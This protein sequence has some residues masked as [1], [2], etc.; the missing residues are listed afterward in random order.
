VPEIRHHLTYANVAAT[1]AL[2]L[3]LGGGVV[4]AASK[5]RGLDIRADAIKSKH[6]KDDSLTGADV[7]ESSLDAGAL[8]QGPPGSPDTAEQVRDK[9]LTVDGPGSGIDA[10]ALDGLDSTKIGEVT[11]ARVN[12]TVQTPGIAEDLDFLTIPGLG[13]VSVTCGNN[14]PNPPG[15]AGWFENLSGSTLD[16]F[17]D[18]FVRN[19]GG[20]PIYK[21]VAPG[22]HSSAFGGGFNGS[23]DRATVYIAEQTDEKP[24]VSTINLASRGTADSCLFIAQASTR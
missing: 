18:D 3:A 16:V 19:G 10:D 12:L 20:P 11:A 8:P 13:R 4:Y 9:L 6:V 17:V 5:I 23:T 14:N 24:R 22:Q 2:L 15:P 21:K 7:L 1:L